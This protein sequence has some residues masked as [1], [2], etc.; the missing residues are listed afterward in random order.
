MTKGLLGGPIQRMLKGILSFQSFVLTFFSYFFSR[1]KLLECVGKGSEGS[2]W[3][4]LCIPMKKEVAIKI[5]DL[6][7]MPT[8]ALEDLRVSNSLSIPIS[9][10]LF[11]LSL[12][13]HFT[14][15]TAI[16]KHT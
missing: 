12:C 9:L 7:S 8:V 4:A 14:S 11:I 10:F 1:Y 15:Y 16:V 6:E 2:V 3:R 5:I 13:Y